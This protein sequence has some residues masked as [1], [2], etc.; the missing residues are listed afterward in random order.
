MSILKTGFWLKS[1][2]SGHTEK[3]LRNGTKWQNVQ[4]GRYDKNYEEM[5]HFDMKHLEYIFA[6]SGYI[7]LCTLF[8]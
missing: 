4:T 8:L 1:W 5:V 7:H 3:C 6:N 2:R